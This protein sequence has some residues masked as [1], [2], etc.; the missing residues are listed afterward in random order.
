VF[1]DR[2]SIAFC[3]SEDEAVKAMTEH[4]NARQATTRLKPA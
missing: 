2:K 4:S 1:A 3:A